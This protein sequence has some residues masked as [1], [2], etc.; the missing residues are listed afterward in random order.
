MALK[1]TAVIRLDPK[2][3]ESYLLSLPDVLDASVWVS[4]GD[5]HAHVT[6]GP[7][8]AMNPEMIRAACLTDLGEQ[9]TPKNVILITSNR[10]AA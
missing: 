4:Q 10:Y 7:N 6:V 3:T 2:N 1:P 9:G 5:L 8:H